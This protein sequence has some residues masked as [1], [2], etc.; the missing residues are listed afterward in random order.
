MSRKYP[1]KPSRLNLSQWLNV[2]IISI[3]AML[4]FSVLVG[5]MLTPPEQTTADSLSEE[6]VI[7]LVQLDFGEI[8]LVKSQGRWLSTAANI[9]GQRAAQIASHWQR[10]LTS[11][12]SQLVERGYA[13]RMVLL[14]FNKRKQPIICKLEQTEQALNIVFVD[15][16]LVFNLPMSHYQ[17]YFPVKE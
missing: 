15:S 17:D 5:R 9:S 8:Q 4:L 13:G 7:E 3:S 16:G 2:V 14:Y 1:H 11:R 12:E 10:L 6:A